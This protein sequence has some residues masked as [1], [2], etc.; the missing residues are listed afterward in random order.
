MAITRN[1]KIASM[2]N[3]A[4]WP[5][6]YD[7]FLMGQ[8]ERLTTRYDSLT[9]IALFNSILEDIA[10]EMR[11]NYGRNFNN[12]EVKRRSHMLRNRYN[13]FVK[14]INQP[15]VQFNRRTNRV[16]VDQSCVPIA[17]KRK[18]IAENAILRYFRQNGFPF[19]DTCE[20]VFDKKK[21]ASIDFGG[22]QGSHVDDPI[23]VDS[24]TSS[25]DSSSDDSI[26]DPDIMLYLNIML[27]NHP[28]KEHWEVDWDAYQ[29][30][31]NV[32]LSEGEDDAMDD[33]SNDGSSDISEASSDVT[34]S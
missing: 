26:P 16:N 28:N 34:Q 4:D 15:G 13:E 29:A 18:K 24:E 19:Y 10:D 30:G 2:F 27:R 32:E 11:R 12:D 14:F 31:V 17:N 20:M 21:A 23:M 1:K 9:D 33:G 3:G 8:L 5:L 6:E 22:G 25:E 7:N